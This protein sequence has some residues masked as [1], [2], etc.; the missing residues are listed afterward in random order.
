MQQ[1]LFILALLISFIV[2]PAIGKEI[3]WEIPQNKESITAPA[4]FDAN[5]QK[6]GE[7]LYLKN[8]KSC[9]G[10]IGMNNMIAL[11][12]L[13]KDLSIGQITKQTNGSIYYKIVNGRGAMPKF[14]DILSVND[15]WN[16]IAYI[17]SF[18][19]GYTQPQPTTIN[20]FAGGAVT[21]KL[22]WFEAENKITIIA[23]GKEKEVVVPA[24]GVE[25]ALYMQRYF[26]QLKLGES[27]FTNK[28]GHATFL[29]DG[30][31]PGDSI[32]K[33]HLFAKIVDTDM[34]GEVQVNDEF[35]AGKPVNKPGL[36]EKRAMWNVVSKAPWWITIAYPAAVLAVMATLFYII[37][38]LRK[39]FILGKK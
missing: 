15:R 31:M 13:P 38:L 24:E 17:R 20:A 12:P 8:C 16:V 36:T 2:K 27:N 39:I 11:D 34:Y 29:L 10:D 25:I 22:K 32:G 7:A 26:G 18:H 23:S 21:L 30:K 28:D 9:H 37:I 5:A 1:Q 35:I 4:M 19:K 3:P 6:V 33:V 14:K